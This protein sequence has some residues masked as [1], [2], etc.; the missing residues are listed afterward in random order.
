VAAFAPFAHDQPHPINRYGGHVDTQLEDT[1]QFLTFQSAGSTYAL[2]VGAIKEIFEC[3]ELTAIPLMPDFILG[4]VNLRGAVVPV[5]DLSARLGLGSSA[6]GRRSAVVIVEVTE[7]GERLDMGLL[8]DSVSGVV[9]LAS[10]DLA[11]APAF[12]ASIRL[13]FI[14]ALALIHGQM[15]AVLNLTHVLSVGEIA[16]LARMDLGLGLECAA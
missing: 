2:A 12:G 11:P 16:E 15:V 4:V 14:A 1:T 9:D 10:P 6:A 7:E 8:V 3:V 13:D 5:I